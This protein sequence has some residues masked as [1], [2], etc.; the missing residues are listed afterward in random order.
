MKRLLVSVLLTIALTACSKKGSG[1]AAGGS[2][3]GGSPSGAS[4]ASQAP[5]VTKLPKL[6]LS[7]DVA[8]EVTVGDAVA[9]EG[10]MLQGAGIGAMQIETWKTPQSIDEAKDDAKMYN[11]KNLQADKLGDGWT[12]SYENTGGAGTNYF[13]TVRRDV[14][15]KS[16]KCSTTGS[17]PDQAK[18]VLAACK[19][20][21]S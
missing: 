17:N 16:Y 8:G 14:G 5:A 20:L 11:P 21:R 2:A 7:I 18:A 6:G 12:L 9:A 19:S 3:S 15:G 4:A 10:H 13:V 1:S